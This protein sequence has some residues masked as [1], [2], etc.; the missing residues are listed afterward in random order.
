VTRDIDDQGRPVFRLWID[1]V[2]MKKGTLNGHK[3]EWEL[4]KP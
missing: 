4:V 1:G 2:M 3:M